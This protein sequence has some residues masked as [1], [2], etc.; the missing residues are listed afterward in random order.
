MKLA[1]FVF[2]GVQRVGIV[3]E[4]DGKL[5]DLARAAERDGGPDDAFAGSDV[6]IDSGDD[7]LERAEQLFLR[8]GREE[9]LSVEMS[10][11]R[12]LAPVPEPRQMRDGMSFPI[13]ILQSQRGRTNDSAKPTG[14]T[15]DRRLLD[16]EPLTGVPEVYQRQPIYYF[17]N[18]FSVQGHEATV[19]WPDYSQ[20]MDYELEF[21]IFTRRTA[22]NIAAASKRGAT[23][24]ASRPPPPP[25]P[26]L[27][28]EGRAKAG[29]GGSPRP[30]ERQELRWGQRA[31]ALDR[32][33]GRDRRPI[34]P[35]GQGESQ[36]SYQG[37]G[38]NERH[39]F[40]FRRDHRLRF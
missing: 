12:L 31:R 20:V 21:G 34:R 14:D 16:R 29:D 15:R 37:V 23:Y 9:D 26:R 32:D 2:R 38:E 3:H 17:T 22:A 18:R 28:R 7:G 25:P 10:S 6:L 27:L 24:S 13:H 19:Y 36:W 30:Y 33:A 8:R 35:E 4:A 1:T 39:A 11:A 40:F 5:F